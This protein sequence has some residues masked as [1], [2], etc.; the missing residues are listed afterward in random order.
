MS[1]QREEAKNI[2]DGTRVQSFYCPSNLE[3]TQSRDIAFSSKNKSFLYAEEEDHLG[4]L[5]PITRIEHFPFRELPFAEES[6]STKENLFPFQGNKIF[7][8]YSTSRTMSTSE[9]S[10][11]TI[12]LQSFRKKHIAARYIQWVE[13]YQ[14][15][16]PSW[17]LTKAP[18]T[19]QPTQ[20]LIQLMWE[21]ESKY[22]R[23]GII[24]DHRS[25]LLQPNAPLPDLSIRK[26]LKTKVRADHIATITFGTE[27]QKKK[28]ELQAQELFLAYI[29]HNLVLEKND[30]LDWS[31]ADYRPDS[32]CFM[33]NSD[34][35]Y[36]YVDQRHVTS[37]S[38]VASQGGGIFVD[39]GVVPSDPSQLFVWMYKRA[40]LKQ[41]I[42]TKSLSKDTRFNRREQTRD[43]L[44]NWWST[45]LSHYSGAN[46]EIRKGGQS[47]PAGFPKNAYMY[48]A[49]WGSLYPPPLY[50]LVEGHAIPSVLNSPYQKQDKNGIWQRWTPEATPREKLNAIPNPKSTIFHLFKGSQA[51]AW[52]LRYL[53]QLINI[54]SVTSYHTFSNRDASL[55]LPGEPRPDKQE[56]WILP[57][58]D[59]L[60]GQFKGQSPVAPFPTDKLFW[61]IKDYAPKTVGVDHISFP[62]CG[63]SYP[64][65][66]AAPVMKEEV[67]NEILSTYYKAVWPQHPS[68][69][70]IVQVLSE[71]AMLPTQTKNSYFLA[72]PLTGW[73]YNLQ[74]PQF[75]KM[76]E[77]K[78]DDGERVAYNKLKVDVT[79]RNSVIDKFP[80]F[81]DLLSG[82]LPRSA[83]YEQVEWLQQLRAY[84][85]NTSVQLRPN[86]YPVKTTSEF[87]QRIMSIWFAYDLMTYQGHNY[88]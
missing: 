64:Y 62:Q 2:V 38:V 82:N 63:V 1:S 42:Q 56:Y 55:I 86:W 88:W 68:L 58:V 51:A 27:A 33:L 9:K 31:L 84:F 14:N 60:T 21:I 40:I 25:L 44:L 69:P 15:R 43:R 20:K 77:W 52:S 29:A 67:V 72:G 78:T 73:Q 17:I 46:T 79:W 80:L 48:E 36:I 35:F 19:S 3:K 28:Q 26:H 87:T 32:L 85:A 18:I 53:L 4:L 30:I 11:I 50:K 41:R 13:T 57:H 6:Y 45:T 83:S 12:W 7:Q 10:S 47:P 75:V 65:N 61:T 59:V 16:T 34:Y 37:Q 74:Q 22:R 49:I 54:P 81:G 76:Q 70:I 66:G 71:L 24:S 8:E 23:A 5:A 39:E